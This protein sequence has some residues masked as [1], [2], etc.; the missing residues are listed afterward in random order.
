MIEQSEYEQRLGN[1]CKAIKKSFTI[2]SGLFS[3]IATKRCLKKIIKLNKDTKNKNINELIYA[4]GRTKLEYKKYCM[5]NNYYTDPYVNRIIKEAYIKLARK[6]MKIETKKSYVNSMKEMVEIDYDSAR[7]SYIYKSLLDNKVIKT[8]EYTID[9]VDDL[10]LKREE[11][12]ERLK[13]LNFG[14]DVFDEL[15][16]DSKKIRKVNPD[17]VNILLNEGKLKHAKM[18]IKEV[19]TGIKLNKPLKITY[20]LDKDSKNGKFGP[21]DNNRMK[22]LAK[23]DKVAT[24]TKVVVKEKVNDKS[25][26]GWLSKLAINKLKKSEPSLAYFIDD[27]SNIKEEDI[28]HNGVS[29]NN[30]KTIKTYRNT[31]TGKIVA[32]DGMKTNTSKAEVKRLL[33]TKSGKVAAYE[34]VADKKARTATKKLVNK[35]TGKVVAYEGSQKVGSKKTVKGI[36]NTNT[37]KIA[38]YSSIDNN[39]RPT[40]GK[41]INTNTGKIAAYGAR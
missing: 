39:R 19:I 22:K 4:L 9:N 13:Q 24:E 31:N 29:S 3:S 35:N 26:L 15:G 34:S 5:D 37:G 38:A 16:I 25:E 6:A 2:K 20:T 21:K 17:I 23:A 40:R 33:N 11:V 32:Y 7:G 10:E 8:R 18:Y 41:V 14:I 30:E 27:L 36:V 28:K 12:V 1:I